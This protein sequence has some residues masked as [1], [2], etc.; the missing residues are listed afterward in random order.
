MPPNQA[1]SSTNQEND[2]HDHQQK[3]ET[4]AEEVEWRPQIKP[5]SPEN[6]DKDNQ[7]QDQAQVRHP[8]GVHAS[9]MQDASD[10]A[11]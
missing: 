5:A 8:F 10:R 11:G 9:T 3:A 1:V 2:D 6:E 7:K 4:A